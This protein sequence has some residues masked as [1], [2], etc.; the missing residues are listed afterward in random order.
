MNRTQIYITPEEDKTLKKLS[1]TTGKSKSELIRTA[2]DQYLEV[3]TESDW[4]NKIMDSAGIW[5][6][7]KDLPDL[8]EIRSSLDRS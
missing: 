2:I 6:G 7:R 5:K 1:K 8:E 3:E 4:K